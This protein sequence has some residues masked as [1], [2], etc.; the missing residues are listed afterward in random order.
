MRKFT[1]LCYF[2]ILSYTAGAQKIPYYFFSQNAWMPDTLGVTNNC[3]GDA[4]GIPCH[5]TGKIHKNNTWEL[6]RQSGAKLIRFGGETPD[7]NKPTV[8]Q[9]LQMIDSAR[10]KGMEPILQV[11]YNNNYYTADTAAAL[12]RFINVTMKRNVKYWSIG[13]EPD[14]APPLGYGYLTASPIADYLKQFSARMKQVDSTII[15][16][17][18]ELKYYNNNHNL[19][20]ELTTP[21]GYYDITGKVPG[22]TYYYIDIIT[23][24][25]YPFGG[26]QT[27]QE[28]ISNLRDGQYF[29]HVLD[30]LKGRIDSCNMYHG[31]AH[32]PLKMAI[33]EAN[34]NYRNSGDPDLNAHSFIGGQFW[35]EM[36]GVGMEKGVEFI[37]F[38]SIIEKSLG[39]IDEETWKLRPTYHHY[40]LMADNFKGNYCTSD[41]MGTVKDLKVIACA[42]SDHI[43]VMLLNQKSKGSKYKYTIQLGNGKMMGKG[44]QIRI[45]NTGILYSNILYTDSIEDESTTML[46]FTPGGQL[47]KKYEYKKY[48]EA[49]RLITVTGTPL[50][51]N[52]GPDIVI[53]PNK[54]IVLSAG[55]KYKNVSYHWYEGGSN[56]PI[57]AKSSN[58]LKV[59]AT[60]NTMYR[61]VVTYDDC[62]IED[63]I[64]V[65]VTY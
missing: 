26:K 10:A 34:I 51:V 43:A 39:Y 58:T 20:D 61:L 44:V 14:L 65:T 24:H 60:K 47:L 28:V 5:L 37:S 48:E 59:I 56:T 40:K 46:V 42:D 33:T 18:P 30:K 23:F 6:V 49:P 2:I 8:Y 32:S 13:N 54:E 17:G 12:V 9:Y 29:S 15:T 64:N 52:A 36:M 45:N 55:N 16:L 1:W 62:I 41:V 21:G 11:P 53:Q 19:I 25:Y 22:H 35:A 7:E 57:N 4:V 31:R 50:L 38:W 63:C 27:R 3:K